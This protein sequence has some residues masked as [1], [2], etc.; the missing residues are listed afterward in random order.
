MI[1]KELRD[2]LDHLTGSDQRKGKKLSSALVAIKTTWNEKHIGKLEQKLGEYRNQLSLRILLLLNSHQALQDQRL[3]AT[4]REIIEVIS[5]NCD[6][7]K[8]TIDNNYLR[9]L[10]YNR[11]EREQAGERHAQTIAAILTGHDGSSRAISGLPHG[12]DSSSASSLTIQTATTYKQTMRK[13]NKLDHHGAEFKTIKFERISQLILDAL[14]FRR[15]DERQDSIIEAHRSTFDWIFRK[16]VVRGTKWDSVSEWLIHGRGCYWISGKAGSGKST[17]LKYL[18]RDPRTRE[19]LLEWSGSSD[20]IVASFYFWYAGTSLQKS[21]AGL[22]RSLILQVLTRRPDLVGVLFPDVCRA[23]I[24]KNLVDNVDFSFGELKRAFKTLLYS[25][26]QNMKICF[27]VDGID[28]YEGVHYEIAELLSQAANSK[29]VKLL[30]SSRP[31]PTCVC[32]FSVFPKLHLEDLTRGDVTTYIEDKLG[33]DSLMRKLEAAQHG[34]TKDLVDSI[35]SKA[36]G[37]FLWVVLVVRSLLSGLQDYDTIPDLRRK[38]DELPPD[39]ETLYEHMLG[40]MSHLNRRQ[41][42]K[43]L[44]LVIRNLEI[45][46]QHPMTALQLSFAEDE[47]YAKAFL[48]PSCEMSSEQLAW[49][50]E[51]IEGRL[52]SRCCGLIEIQKSSES[53]GIDARRKI[54]APFH[55][56]VVEFLRLSTIWR[57]LTSLTY[58]TEFDA[59][60]ALISSVLS[61]MRLQSTW[62]GQAEQDSCLSS[63]VL[64]FI[65]YEKHLFDTR[66]SLHSSFLSSLQVSSAHSWYKLPLFQPTNIEPETRLNEET[67]SPKASWT[68]LGL[69]FPRSLLLF[70]ACQH[71]AQYTQ[72]LLACFC[73]QRSPLAYSESLS[74]KIFVYL[75]LQLIDGISAPVQ[76]PVIQTTIARA[77]CRTMSFVNFR[78]LQLKRCWTA[79]ISGLRRDLA[80][81]ECFTLWDFALNYGSVLARCNEGDLSHE[82]ISSFLDLVICC[83]ESGAGSKMVV[84]EGDDYS[85]LRILRGLLSKIW[86]EIWDAHASID[87]SHKAG[88]PSACDPQILSQIECKALRVESLAEENLAVAGVCEQADEENLDPQKSENIESQCSVSCEKR[89][90]NWHERPHSACRKPR[91]NCRDRN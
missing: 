23:I 70:A 46:D 24:S 44:Q 45:H 25:T 49:R 27:I 65:S 87:S 84:L 28:E 47:D 48:S 5:L 54:I 77:A 80:A 31:V 32:V 30:L 89:R 1:V 19:A 15:I 35:S 21:Q 56:T 43:L 33:K 51:A 86:V 91:L 53:P 62:S 38:L 63:S 81:P 57:S 9:N 69:A 14:Y 68:K 42:S 79:R 6:S 52:R 83:M 20:L 66:H 39:L 29:S 72:V 10:S 26:P 73:S 18:H 12:T 3:D 71:S 59:D 75:V 36:S 13:M 88:Y 41:G 90:S 82:E 11:R 78:D 7:L 8:S 34:A 60:L 22:L 50:Y 2:Y 76:S 37:V 85:A 17:L 58:E 61:E 55:R 64:R 74:I 4:K 67:S 16:P 40:N